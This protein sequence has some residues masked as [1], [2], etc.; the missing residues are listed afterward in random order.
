[1]AR[2]DIPAG[3]GAAETRVWSLHPDVGRT[4]GAVIDMIYN[5]SVLPARV[6]EA[7]RMRIAQIND[8]P[9]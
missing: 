1:M 9:N 7:A 8:C 2:I 4:A 6:R 3:D 5:R